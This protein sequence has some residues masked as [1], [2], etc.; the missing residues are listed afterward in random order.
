[1]TDLSPSPGNGLVRSWPTSEPSTSYKV[2][3][4]VKGGGWRALI[5]GRRVNNYDP[6]LVSND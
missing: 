6:R 3:K 4:R 1:M 5:A 2:G